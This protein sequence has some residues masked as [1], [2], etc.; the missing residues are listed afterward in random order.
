MS[1]HIAGD[2]L[3]RVRDNTLFIVKEVIHDKIYVLMNPL[4]IDKNA[5]IQF[6]N[7]YWIDE[8]NTPLFNNCIDTSKQPA[9][10]TLMWK[11]DKSLRVISVTDNAPAK[12]YDP[13]GPCN[14]CFDGKCEQCIYGYRPHDSVMK[15]YNELYNPRTRYIVHFVCEDNSKR[16]YTLKQCFE[17]LSLI[18][19]NI[20]ELTKKVLSYEYSGENKTRYDDIVKKVESDMMKEGNVNEDIDMKKS[21]GGYVKTL[22]EAIED[23]EKDSYQKW[24]DSLHVV[25]VPKFDL[26][27]FIRKKAYYIKRHQD[28]VQLEADALLMSVSEDELEFL[29]IEGGKT[30]DFQ[31]SE[32]VKIPIKEYLNGIWTIKR[33]W[34]EE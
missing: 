21:Y 8:S 27:Y 3:W 20:S 30:V 29:R 5:D 1:K 18:P 23:T 24:K 10:G 4:N 9:V 6:V 14:S 22:T 19:Y 12:P 13:K 17:E 11:G 26:K 15:E 16:D 31:V 33:L 34:G 7:V 28:G 32:L 2:M 25:N